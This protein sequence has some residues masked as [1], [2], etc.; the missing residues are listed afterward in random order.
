MKTIISFAIE[1]ELLLM[2]DRRVEEG[3]RSRSAVLREAVATY[4]GNSEDNTATC[5]EEVRQLSQ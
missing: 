1:K 2:L 4:I 5:D 3:D